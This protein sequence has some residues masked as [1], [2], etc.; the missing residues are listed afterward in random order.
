MGISVNDGLLLELEL[1]GV[2]S[3]SPNAH[4]TIMVTVNLTKDDIVD[5]SGDFAPLKCLSIFKL[6]SKNTYGIKLDGSAPK[7]SFQIGISPEF[8]ASAITMT[9]NDHW[10][11]THLHPHPSVI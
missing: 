5:R 10:V 2:V 1:A 3:I 8:P 11:V 7:F 6:E 4:G 9:S